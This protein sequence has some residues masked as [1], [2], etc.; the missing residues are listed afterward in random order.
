[1]TIPQKI[2]WFALIPSIMI[3][4]T[5]AAAWGAIGEKVAQTQ[6]KIIQFDQ[7]FKT[8]LEI[9]KIR[10]E[11]SDAR[12]LELKLELSEIKGQNK[13]II[14]RIENLKK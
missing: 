13:A 14:E 10:D 4:L 8:L 12:Y 7:N 5:G 2:T 9:Q 11:I 3:L 1:M 6:S